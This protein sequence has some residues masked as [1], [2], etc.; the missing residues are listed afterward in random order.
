MAQ[1]VILITDPGIDGACAAALAMYDPDLEVLALAATAGNVSAD[2]A[3]RNVHILIE[4]MDPPRWPRVGEAPPVT[5]DVNGVKLHGPGGLGG[6]DFPCARLHHPHPSEKLIID[7][8]RQHPREVTVLLLGPATVMA[9][10]LDR[11]PELPGLIQRLIMV[12]GVQHEP[13]DV[14]AVADFHFYCDPPA[15]RQV[16]QSGATISLLPL[17]ATRKVMF[18]PR[19][20]LQLPVADSPAYQ[21]L[22]RIVPHGLGASASLYGIE[23]LYLHD[24]LAVAVAS[25][26]G[27]VAS[28]PAVVDVETRGELTRGMSVFDARW[29]ITARPNVDVVTTVDVQ[30]VRGYILKTLQRE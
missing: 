17:D 1:K 9:R 2:E 12:G 22:R 4:Q 15:A 29:G 18:S 25:R 24:V 30:A 11:D 19:D 13:G 21:F 6:I 3:T 8:V 26:P 7:L 14:S 27:S 23:G 20:L 5:Y 16:L 10:T 28:H